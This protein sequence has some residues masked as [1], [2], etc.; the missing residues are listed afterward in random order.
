MP[1]TALSRSPQR[2]D[3][4]EGVGTVR[5]ALK[6]EPAAA[7]TQK[8]EVESEEVKDVEDVAAEGEDEYQREWVEAVGA[9]AQSQQSYHNVVQE[10]GRLMAKARP[11]GKGRAAKY[12]PY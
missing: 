3:G 11:S 10:L 8:D 9:L 4:D 2:P 7:P 12:A 1:G 5:R 6:A